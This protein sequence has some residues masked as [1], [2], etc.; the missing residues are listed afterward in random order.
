MFHSATAF[1]DLYCIVFRLF[2][3]KWNQMQ[4]GYMGF[5][6]VIDEVKESVE[7]LL[8]R[9]SI[10]GVPAIFDMLGIFL[11]DLSAFKANAEKY[12]SVKVSRGHAPNCF[13]FC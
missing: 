12:A 5:Q 2:D 7:E 10:C 3:Q 11:E 6:K 9:P 1:E 8:G 4:V 13:V